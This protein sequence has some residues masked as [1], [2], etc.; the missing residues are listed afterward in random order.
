MAF[1][2]GNPGVRIQNNGFA[3]GSVKKKIKSVENPYPYES[4]TDLTP[5]LSPHYMKLFS[6]IKH[7]TLTIGTKNQDTG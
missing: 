4:R 5:L 7:N 2:I 1:E 3:F 6:T